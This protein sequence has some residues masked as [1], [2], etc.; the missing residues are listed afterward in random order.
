MPIIPNQPKVPHSRGIQ[1]VDRIDHVN[2]TISD[3]DGGPKES[4]PNPHPT[5]HLSHASFPTPID[6]DACPPTPPSLAGPSPSLRRRAPETRTPE[7]EPSPGRPP[8]GASPRLDMDGLARL[9]DGLAATVDPL[10]PSDRLR[11]DAAAGPGPA[12]ADGL[13]AMDEWDAT[14]V[15]C[16]RVRRPAARGGRGA[17]RV[18]TARRELD[19][20]G[21][22]GEGRPAR[23]GGRGGGSR[24]GR[25]G[26]GGRRRGAPSPIPFSRYPPLP[27]TTHAVVPRARTG[28]GKGGSPHI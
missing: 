16:V 19:G 5:L 12:A 3:G 4:P 15:S 13:G 11:C 7:T 25:A 28:R 27:P 22:G 8:R 18:E 14:S 6:A 20:R 10:P 1:R 17:K 21:E 24:G 26:R 9:A 2:P 23:R